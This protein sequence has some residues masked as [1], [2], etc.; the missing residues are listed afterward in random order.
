MSLTFLLNDPQSP[1]R[2]YL[3]GI[4]PHL[5]AMRG[6]SDA[7]RA[8][9]EALG[10][11]ELT[12]RTTVRS[13]FP[14]ADLR[15][16]GTALDF[17]A[18][19]ELGGFDARHSVAAAGIAQLGDYAPFVENGAHRVKILTEA[20][21][22]AEMLLREPFSDSELDRAA[23]LLAYCEQVA[24]KG[25]EAMNGSLGVFCD[26]AVDGRSFADR[27]DPRVLADIRSLMVSNAAQLE[28]WQEQIAGG[29]RYEPNPGFAGS[30]L[31]G[32]ADAD[33]V[34]GETLIDCKVYGAL[35][36]PKL[37]DFIR[38]LLGYVMLDSDD[39]LGIRRVGIWLPRQR[40][41]PS[42]SLTHLLSG[43]PE[44]LLP[45]LRQGFTKATGRTQL[46][47][48][49]P[50]PMRRMRQQ[51]ADNRHTPYEK[52]AMLAMSEDVDIRRRVGRN[53]V[54]PEATVRMLAGDG[55]WRVREGV[56]MNDSAPEDVLEALA[57][58]RSVAVRRAV[59]A[60]LGASRPLAKALA[61]ETNHVISR[62]LR[63]IDDS[64]N[65]LV[66]GAP[67]E[68]E[69]F[70]AEYG[71]E[72]QIC[73]NRDDSALDS[74]WFS[75]F[76]Q[77]TWGQARLPIPY[78]S[79]R[80]GLQSG[81][82]LV[83]EE[84]M[85]RGL[86]DQV[87]ADLIRGD[88]PSWVRRAVARNLE[89]SDPALRESLLGDADPE[90]RWL[91]LERTLHHPGEDL[92]SLL[93]DLAA[94]R[95]ARL[96]FRTAG[97]AARREWR[98][99]AAEYEHQTICL[100][101]AH[102]STPYSTLLTLMA[103]SSA[104]VLANLVENPSL[105]DD[106]RVLLVQSL[107]TSKSVATRELLA[108]IE[109]VPE[110]VL[111]ELAT[112]RD[113]RV[114]AA[115]AKHHATPLTALSRLAADHKRAVQLSVLENL[116]TPADLARSTAEALLL[117]DVDEDLHQVLDLVERRA[118][119]DLPA[120]VI[121]DALDRL[122]KSRVRDPDMRCVVASDRRSSVKTLSRLARSAENSVR[123]AIATNPHTPVVVLEH[124]AGDL[125][126]GVRAMVARNPLSP[127]TVLEILSQDDNSEVRA[128]TAGNPNLP[129]SRLESLLI[130][131]EVSVRTAALKSPAMPV[132]LV[133]ETEA[134][135][136]LS[137]QRARPD[138][139]VLEKMVADK[140]AEVRM[141][142]AFNPTADAD[143]L[144]LLGGERASTRVRRAVAANPNT[145][146]AVLRSLAE[147]K[148][149]QVR[150]ALAFNGATPGTLLAELAGRSIDLA[151]LVTMNPDVPGA[152]LDA[153]AQD[154]DPLIR[155]FAD[156]S[157]QARVIPSSGNTQ[158]ALDRSGRAD[159]RKI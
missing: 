56:A 50:I 57:R 116:V 115:V 157:R 146:A 128:Q 114:R 46:A 155:F 88:R 14:G 2:A 68:A 132:N 92:S 152:V 154:S 93:V 96:R 130:D 89:I 122:S 22:L 151:I 6:R 28:T 36:V 150:Q 31:V 143:L 108:S 49:S 8:A 139:A 71:G 16:T 70:A 110:T 21:G 32:G 125:E 3:D 33:W 97:M 84:W 82:P 39:S 145:P 75:E 35:T 48:H 72:V 59:A 134:E 87:L 140:R 66:G 44:E 86:P 112:D 107:Q 121:E 79:Y 78:A 26:A 52:L 13:S 102:P 80:W 42:W 153:L 47:P 24:R 7:A 119:V 20:F 40:L 9:A 158:R 29:D 69:G 65:A 142:V 55:H 104:E 62:D 27:L 156:C 37:R 54:A 135:L 43:D 147:D 38:Q 5:E 67:I 90:I 74:T 100:L 64:G 30:R 63:A 123:Q 118:D 61:A 124:L 85:Q 127:A 137:G 95:E 138:R 53:A 144:R 117:V 136:V 149:D 23:I 81:R 45:S 106:D 101:A 76:L 159:A 94:S 18:R 77:M 51:L 60:N 120:R 133:R 12:R 113:V 83:V 19:I 99:T 111:I 58:D 11:S 141:E 109:S 41:M 126:P 98:C 91:T 25:A 10:L 1:V 17:R 34:I 103:N 73:Q 105:R 148:D 129:Q 131:E 4:S 15:L